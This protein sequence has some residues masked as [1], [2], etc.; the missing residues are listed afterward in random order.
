MGNGEELAAPRPILKL[1]ANEG[2]KWTAKDN[3]ATYS[4]TGGKAEVIEVPAGKFKAIPIT[5]DITISTP[6]G[7]K[8]MLTE[9]T[10]F[11]PGAGA[12]N[13]VVKSPGGNDS[14]TVLKSIPLGK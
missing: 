11:A 1:P 2:D 10:W 14:E 9:T 3:N 13:R 4:Y 5:S 8:G 6:G 12:V 7:K